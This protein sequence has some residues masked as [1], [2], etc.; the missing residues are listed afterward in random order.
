MEKMDHLVFLVYL[1]RWVPGVSLD[2][3][4]LMVYLV[5]QEFLALKVKTITINS[6]HYL[7]LV[8]VL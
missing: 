8:F 1:E 2:R 5:H 4:D 6:R 3:E 7:I